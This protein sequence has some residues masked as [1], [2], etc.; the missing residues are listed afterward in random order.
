MNFFGTFTTTSAPFGQDVLI[1]SVAALGGPVV[2][3]VGQ[4]TFRTNGLTDQKVGFGLTVLVK[5]TN[6]ALFY[7]VTQFPPLAAS[8]LDAGNNSVLIEYAGSI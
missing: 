4:T 6:I 8:T 2:E 1:I 3:N 5:V 7:S